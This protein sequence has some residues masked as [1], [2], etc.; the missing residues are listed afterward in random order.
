MRRKRISPP[1]SS[2]NCWQPPRTPRI[3]RTD[4]AALAGLTDAELAAAA[5]A[6][7]ERKVKGWVIPLQNT[8]QQ[9]DLQSLS[10]RD[11]RRALFQ[12]SWSRAEHGDKNDTRAD[13]ARLA[14]LRARKAKLLG[15]PNY[16]AW[17][18]TDQ[19]AK[20]P[21]AALKF[22]DALVPAATAKAEGEGDDIQALI[23][24]S[25][26]DSSSSRGTGTSMPS[27]SAKRSSISTSPRPS[28]TSN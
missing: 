14:Q 16:A 7:K 22:M 23:D 10:N 5:V 17:K 3:S 21:A 6:A 13:I 11:T 2:P 27:R 8:T 25:T 20:T 19:M 12:N 15:F 9:P 24:R 28:R 26:A 4:K 18:L 1:H